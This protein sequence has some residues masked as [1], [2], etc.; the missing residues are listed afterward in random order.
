MKFQKFAK[1]LQKIEETSSRNAMIDQVAKLLQSLDKKEVAEAMYLMQGRVVPRFVSLEFNVAGKLMIR[2]LAQVFGLSGEDI[3]NSFKRL[4]DLGLVAEK[5]SKKKRSKLSVVDVY[6]QLYEIASLGGKDSQQGKID[7]IADLIKMA[8]SLSCRYIVRM[9]LGNLRLGFSDKSVLDA[10]SIAAVGD[11]SKRPLLDKAYGARSDIGFIAE[12][13]LTK[14]IESLGRI[15][16][17]P[18]VP[19]ASMLCER[20]SSVEK[21]FERGTAWIVQPKYDGL[22]CQIHFDAKGF[23]LQAEGGR[24]KQLIKGEKEKVRIFSRNLESL[25]KMFP[26]VVEAVSKLGVKSIILDTEAVGYNEKTEE[27]YPFQETIQR[28]RKYEVK[29]LASKIPVK[30]FAFDILYLDGKDLSELGLKKRL[31]ILEKVIAKGGSQDVIEFAPSDEVTS[32]D[33][34]EEKLEEY[35]ER[36]IEGVIAKNPESK[37]EPGKRGFDWIKFKKSAKGYLVDN[38]DAVVLGYYSGRG[39]RAKFGIG[40]ILVGVLN[41][42]SNK[43]ESIAKVGTGIKDEEWGVIK[44]RLDKISAK[45]L[46][47]DAEVSKGLKPHVCVKPEVVVVIDADEITKSPNHRAGFSKGKGYSLRFPRLKEFDRRDREA[48]DITTVDEIERLYKLQGKG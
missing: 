44:K 27:F 47:T 32:P 38:V 29:R 4:G 43:F 34:F 11:K 23:R 6:N 37:Y 26:D 18:G 8:D 30:V 17:E 21:I 48:E 13:V 28:R 39:A 36:G 24:Q 46:P 2:A 22:R 9:T 12:E 41:K 7:G 45:K 19:L 5:N 25:T 16:I 14:G 3:N 10:L 35:I 40:A 1:I 33:I 42:K 20:E 31:E 15:E